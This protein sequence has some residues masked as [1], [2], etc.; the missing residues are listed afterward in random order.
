MSSG[1]D[2]AGS[3]R[4]ATRGRRPVRDPTVRQERGDVRAALADR[5]AGRG[6]QDRSGGAVC[7]GGGGPGGAARARGLGAVPRRGL[8][9]SARGA[10]AVGGTGRDPRGDLGGAADRGRAGAARGA[11]RANG[12]AGGTRGPRRRGRRPSG[13]CR[14]SGRRCG[15]SARRRPRRRRATTAG[16]AAR[17][18]AEATGVPMLSERAQ[19]AVRALGAAETPSERG[20]GPGRR[21]R[22]MVGWPASWRASC[23]RWR[24][25]SGP[26]RC[27]RWTGAGP[28]WRRQAVCGRQGVDR[29]TL[30]E[31]GRVVQAVRHGE[32]AGAEGQ[33]LAE[34]ARMRAG[35][36]MRP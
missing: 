34:G 19:E 6:G 12:A 23:G 27:G 8:P 24:G 1:S 17:R 32:R 10:G 21:C 31:I 7:G 11:G 18:A 22:P 36:K 26:T 30:G 16:I 35:P 9:R 33:R 29:A 14:R 20:P 2:T 28:G 4:A 25:G 5:A 15:A 3:D 13:W